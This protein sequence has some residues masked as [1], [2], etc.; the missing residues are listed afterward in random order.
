MFD[1]ICLFSVS[2]VSLPVLLKADMKLD[3]D[4]WCLLWQQK[5][6]NISLEQDVLQWSEK[7]AEKLKKTLVFKELLMNL[8][9][10]V[11]LVYI[12]NSKYIPKCLENVW[13]HALK[14]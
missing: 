10:A 14:Y 2:V 11:F 9:N 4:S 5:F 1:T 7:K 8:W 13:F 12:Q 6:G 3:S